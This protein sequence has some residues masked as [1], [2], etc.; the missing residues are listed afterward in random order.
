MIL[1]F[2]QFC[3]FR[4]SHQ[5]RNEAMVAIIIEMLGASFGKLALSYA[6]LEPTII[7]TTNN[8]KTTAQPD[9]IQ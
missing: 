2:G 5:I 6:T 8:N 4:E 3:Y 1:A 9:E 7:N